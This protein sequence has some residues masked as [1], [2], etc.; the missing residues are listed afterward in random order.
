MFSFSVEMSSGSP[1]G[2]EGGDPV[3]VTDNELSVA[4]SVVKSTSSVSWKSARI[5]SR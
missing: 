4:A 2:S 3:L 1:S 5:I